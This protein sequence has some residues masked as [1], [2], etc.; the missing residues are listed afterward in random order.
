MKQEW[1][2]GLIILINILKWILIPL[3]SISLLILSFYPSG[4]GIREETINEVYYYQKQAKIINQTMANKIYH[5]QEDIENEL[6][7]LIDSKFYEDNSSYLKYNR[8]ILSPTFDDVTYTWNENGIKYKE[9][10]VP[11]D[12]EIQQVQKYIN[13]FYDD[14]KEFQS[15]LKSLNLNDKLIE[16]INR[17][18]IY[19]PSI[20]ITAVSF[21]I[22]SL[23]GFIILIFLYL[24]LFSIEIKEQNEKNIKEQSE[25]KEKIKEEELK[26]P[27]KIKPVLDYA[28]IELQEQ[29]SIIRK[30]IDRVFVASIIF[31]IIGVITFLIV[32]FKKDIPNK[33]AIITTTG[34]VMTE[35]VGGIFLIMY[36][37]L[38]SQLNENLKILERFN[39]IGVGSKIIDTLETNN[40]EEINKLK[41]SL[42]E[43]IIDKINY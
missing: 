10:Y 17:N 2:K 21:L 41:I 27:E 29:I 9:L 38:I 32:I 13:K 19:T 20:K 28:K 42:A 30:H 36:K 1:K 4:W 3:F 6:K 34:G 14:Y 25:K 15:L 26:N 35:I 12:D 24:I 23:L 33:I 18:I 22:S 39:I 31:L 37:S 8:D 40:I 43:K 11:S 7:N 16:V 5:S